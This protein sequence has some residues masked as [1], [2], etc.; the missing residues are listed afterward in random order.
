MEA[1]ARSPNVHVKV[2][3]LGL[4]DR[5]WTVEGNRGVVLDAIAIFGMDRCMFG[6]NFPVAGLFA[7]YATIL[8]GMFDILKNRPRAEL[9][10]FFYA[11]ALRFYR[12]D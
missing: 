12:I 8:H 6:S 4:P 7:P 11:N 2:S 3:E 9:D 10:A 1:L 5:P